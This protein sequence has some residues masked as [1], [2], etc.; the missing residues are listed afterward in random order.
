MPIGPGEPRK[1]ILPLQADGSRWF[2]DGKR[3]VFVGNEPGRPR[4]S[5]EYTI[6]SGKA[7]PLT[8]EGTTG[9]VVSPDGRLL[10][11]STTEGRRM[12]WPIDGGT[13]REVSGLLPQDAI[14]AWA[15]DGRSLWVSGPTTARRS[16]IARLDLVTGRRE[17]LLTFGPSDPAGVRATVG[18]PFVSADGRTYAYSYRHLLSDLF[19]GDGLQPGAAAAAGR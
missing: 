4:R 14:V 15:T 10:I 11:A 1:L 17:R 13:P 19:I 16:D 8:P 3:L 7:R 2:P 6:E 9:T 12:L 5:Y 18:A